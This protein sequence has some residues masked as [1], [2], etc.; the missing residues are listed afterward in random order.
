MALRGQQ[1][2]TLLSFSHKRSWEVLHVDSSRKASPEGGIAT[3]CH[4]ILTYH[5]IFCVA[6]RSCFNIHVF[7]GQCKSPV[8]N[9][10]S[11]SNKFDQRIPNFSQCR[12]PAKQ[13]VLFILGGLCLGVQWKAPIPPFPKTTVESTALQC[14]SFFCYCSAIFKGAR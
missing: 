14:I 8:E 7:M 2:R 9:K 6:C 11:F 5:C 4:Y 10:S 12:A 3:L 13:A 1:V